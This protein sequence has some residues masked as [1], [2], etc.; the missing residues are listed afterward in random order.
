[1]ID[2]LTLASAD[3]DL[4]RVAST[5]GGE[6]HGP[7]PVCGGQD[8]FMV[9]PEQAP[10]G[11]FWCRQCHISGDDVDYLV[12]IRGMSKR[13]ALEAC[14]RRR[15]HAQSVTNQSPQC[16]PD[17]CPP[18]ILPAM[19]QPDDLPDC[20]QTSA[21]TLCDEAEKRLWS[22]A[23]QQAR[24]Y[25]NR[26]SLKISTIRAAGLGFIER[27][28]REDPNAWGLDGGKQVWIPGPS[29]VI[30]KTVGRTVYGVKFRRLADDDPKYV[31]I[32]DS[33]TILYGADQAGDFRYMVLTEGEF[34][35]LLLRQEAGDFVAVATLGSATEDDFP[36]HALPVILK[37]DRIL[38]AYDADGAGTKGTVKLRARYPGLTRIL[39]KPG[40]GDLTDYHMV[41][42]SLRAW[43]LD[44]LAD[45][46]I[47]DY[48]RA[49]IQQYDGGVPAE[50]IDAAMWAA[51]KRGYHATIKRSSDYDHPETAFSGT[52]ARRPGGSPQVCPAAT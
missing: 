47:Y 3:I 18:K 46:G 13:E 36:A 9:W 31:Q 33:R 49:A 19:A 22:D 26:R 28:H 43:L 51:L 52:A 38:I 50:E 37:L 4:K 23:G 34:D 29:I 41:G 39:M 21:R 11:R 6:Y 20:W 2:L 30:P 27:D 1:M 48:E 5:N 42:G 25:L 10:H 8:R 14:G 45:Q 32:R 17:P 16:V 24:E 12:I 40:S 35:C 7:C 44:E 15:Q